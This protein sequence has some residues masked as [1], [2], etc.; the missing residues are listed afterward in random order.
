MTTDEFYQLLQRAREAAMKAYWEVWY[1]ANSESRQDTI[2]CLA[3]LAGYTGTPR[4][5]M[6][7][8]EDIVN[9][10]AV[11]TGNDIEEDEGDEAEV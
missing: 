7:T 6:G 3:S 2:N 8:D 5:E 10:F 4:I 9:D 1:D 11:M